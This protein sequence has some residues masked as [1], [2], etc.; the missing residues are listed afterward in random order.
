[1]EKRKLTGEEKVLKVL[2]DFGKQS[3]S[4][5]SWNS[6]LNYNEALL[7]LDKLE[8]QSKVEK[9]ELGKITYWELLK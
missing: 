4:K 2:K 9:E 8:K 1:M 5:I 6:H 7:I 3:S